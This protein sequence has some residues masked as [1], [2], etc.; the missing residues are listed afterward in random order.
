[1]DWHGFQYRQTARLHHHAGD[2]GRDSLGNLGRPAFNGEG[3]GVVPWHPVYPGDP[4]SLLVLDLKHPERVSDLRRILVGSTPMEDVGPIECVKFIAPRMVVA[5]N[6]M[7][8]LTTHSLNATKDGFVRQHKFTLPE[9]SYFVEFDFTPSILKPTYV[10]VAVVSVAKTPAESALNGSQ[11]A[12]EVRLIAIDKETG[13]IHGGE[14]VW[15][16]QTLIS[17][18]RLHGDRLTFTDLNAA[19]GENS[20]TLLRPYSEGGLVGSQRLWTRNIRLSELVRR[21]DGAAMKALPLWQD[22]PNLGEAVC[23]HE[24][25]GSGQYM[26]GTM[27]GYLVKLDTQ[28]GGAPLSGIEDP[29]VS[30]LDSF[31]LGQGLAVGS[32]LGN[33]SVFRPTADGRFRLV[34]SLGTEP[35]DHFVKTD[36][37]GVSRADIYYATPVAIPG[38]AHDHVFVVQDSGRFWLL[39]FAKEPKTENSGMALSESL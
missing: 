6:R 30:S 23:S 34:G 14:V 15:K 2:P 19:T 21:E 22:E 33:T 39:G 18:V 32:G 4:D 25:I 5:M 38:T 8:H 20:L 16:T 3:L 28:V 12:S 1:M 37:F 13:A 9:G 24:S 31:T 11:D 35:D 36:N 27:H 10:L 7:G 29:Y 17:S 26:L